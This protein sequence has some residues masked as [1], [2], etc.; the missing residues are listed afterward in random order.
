MFDRVTG[1]LRPKMLSGYHYT[2]AGLK[3]FA[4][5]IK[6]SLYDD[7]A[8]NRN[9]QQS[10][11]SNSHEEHTMDTGSNTQGQP[12]RNARQEIHSFLDMAISR[13]GNL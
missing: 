7:T 5:E 13:L 9:A 2:P 3:T 8:S 1:R 12:T 6:R 4:K 10:N 11:L